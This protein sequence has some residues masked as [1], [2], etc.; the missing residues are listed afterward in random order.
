M[1]RGGARRV[2]HQSRREQ[3]EVDDVPSVRWKVSTDL[4]NPRYE[5]DA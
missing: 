1:P 3:E 4:T 5:Q 2:E